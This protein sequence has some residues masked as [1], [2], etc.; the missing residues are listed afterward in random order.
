M[1]I[2][3]ANAAAIYKDEAGDQ[4]WRHFIDI[5]A[6]LKQWDAKF[7]SGQVFRT[8]SEVW[9][10]YLVPE[11]KKWI[12][13]NDMLMFWNKHRLTGDNVKVKERPYTNLYPRLTVR[14]NRFKVHVCAQ[15][16]TK[17]KSTPPDVWIP[18]RDVVSGEYRGSVILKRKIGDGC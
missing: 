8:A 9:E 16:L 13:R 15:A 10:M 11:G 6:T 3:P 17:V 4:K 5:E 12:G 1:L 2:I 18:G 7:A 14:S